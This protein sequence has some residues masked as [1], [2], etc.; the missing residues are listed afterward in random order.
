MRR[1]REEYYNRKSIIAVLIFFI[2]QVLSLRPP[3]SWM[4]L[5]CTMNK[6]R[7]N[8]GNNNSTNIPSCLY[9]RIIKILSSD[10]W[11]GNPYGT[12]EVLEWSERFLLRRLEIYFSICLNHKRPSRQWRRFLLF[13][14]RRLYLKLLLEME[15]NIWGF[16]GES[17]L[18]VSGYQLNKGSF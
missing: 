3:V 14:N 15:L 12:S 4:K 9:A 6:L 5:Y 2:F 11:S 1:M 7:V 17:L 18:D 16:H 13:H 10:M 8:C